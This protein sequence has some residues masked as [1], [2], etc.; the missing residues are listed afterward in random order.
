MK[1]VTE[2]AKSY[3]ATGVE[4]YPEP[5]NKTT[6]TFATWNTFSGTE[7]YFKELGYQKIEKD[8]GDCSNFIAQWRKGSNKSCFRRAFLLSA[9]FIVATTFT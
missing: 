3:N 7:Q 5:K 1:S 2:L 6:G 4:A 8:F 9:K